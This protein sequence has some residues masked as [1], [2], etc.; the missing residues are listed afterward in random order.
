M[1]VLTRK[2]QQQIQIGDSI[3]ITILSVRG[4][5]VQVGVT[6]PTHVRVVRGEL[7]PY[8]G[9]AAGMEARSA[10][11]GRAPPCVQSAASGAMP[12]PGGVNRSDPARRNASSSVA[13]PMAV[14]PCQQAGV[15]AKNSPLARAVAQRRSAPQ[16]RPPQRLGAASL[17]WLTARRS[18]G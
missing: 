4:G 10:A 18:R 8:E 3:T 6:A 2:Q 11:A 9:D 7:S 14:P 12:A 13:E 15:R 17:G 1:L 16:V 5:R